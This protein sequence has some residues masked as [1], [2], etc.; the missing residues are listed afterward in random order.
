MDTKTALQIL[1]QLLQEIATELRTLERQAT[2]SLSQENNHELY[3][4]LQEEK[5]KLLIALP[6]KVAGHLAELEPQIR[7]TVEKGLLE[8]AED[9]QMAQKVNSPFYMS[10]LLAPEENQEEAGLNS[11]DN[12]IAH[13]ERM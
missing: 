6:T 9:A 8:F 10:V 1:I 5:T 11:F 13:L 2:Q 4:K 12:F 3:R 7:L